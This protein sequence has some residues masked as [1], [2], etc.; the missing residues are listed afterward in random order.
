MQDFSLGGGETGSCYP[1]LNRKVIHMSCTTLAADPKRTPHRPVTRRSPSR[2]QQQTRLLVDSGWCRQG[3]QQ[4]PTRR[5]AGPLRSLL[6]R[7][8]R[9]AKTLEHTPRSSARNRSCQL[10]RQTLI[11]DARSSPTSRGISTASGTAPRRR[12]PRMVPMID[13]VAMAST[14]P[15][16][17][18]RTSKLRSRL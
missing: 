18:R 17:A 11:A 5:I 13:P 9:H 7:P 1:D 12:P 2:R 10:W 3:P 6:S 15:L 8:C 4:Q 16:V 14:K